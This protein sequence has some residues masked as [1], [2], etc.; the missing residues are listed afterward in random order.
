MSV[1]LSHQAAI[2]ICV[3]LLSEVIFLSSL[4]VSL[5]RVENEAQRTKHARAVQQATV[6]LLRLPI[7]AGSTLG[8]FAL[9]KSS[10]LDNQFNAIMSKLP[11]RLKVL[12][13]LVADNKKQ[14]DAVKPLER[15]FA[16]V[17]ANLQ[18]IRES[19]DG[20]ASGVPYTRFLTLRKE[21][22]A[23]FKL[24]SSQ[25]RKIL[26]I[27]AESV[28][29]ETDVEK[30]SRKQLTTSIIGGIALTVILAVMLAFQF[31][32][33]TQKRLLLLMDNTRRLSEN[34]P[35]QK[36]LNGNDELAQLDHVFHQM[37][38]SLAE[39]TRK[40]RAIVEKAADVICSITW[41]DRFTAVNP[42]SLELWGWSPDELVGRSYK[43]ILPEQDAVLMSRE[44]ESARLDSDSRRFE[45][46]LTKKD[47]TVAYMNWSVYSSSEQ[48]SYFCVVHDITDRKEIERLKQDFVAMVSHDLMT[49]LTS[50]RLFLDML[51]EGVYGTISTGGEARINLVDDNV[52][53]LLL[54]VTNL[55]DLE[56]LE[57]GGVTLYPQ[58][59]S[60]QHLVNR[61]VESV[62]GLAH[63]LGVTVESQATD[64]ISLVADGDRIVQVLVN[65]LSNAVKFSK[66]GDMVTVVGSEEDGFLLVEVIDH[67]P[68]I[69]S[70]HQKTIFER[71]KQSP[72]AS[73]EEK[74]LGFGFGLYMAKSMVNLHG[75][76]IGVE[77][78]EGKGS[79][80]WFTLPLNLESVDDSVST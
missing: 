17:T 48:E 38:E 44:L 21:L 39:A 27:E 41:T 24:M 33:S 64:E 76:E 13:M 18:E 66:S 73:T 19:I 52:N 40:E 77:S 22:D 63:E 29:L 57:V 37:A 8:T 49:P 75:G 67:G 70:E 53:R 59:V 54:L 30:D 58:P 68:G 62:V 7:D 4:L 3:P 15:S 25:A 78:E 20:D 61:S 36:R 50:V 79:T 23:E 31:F 65:L 71:F 51:R 55:L 60:F 42:A 47:G 35:L 11:E 10:E 26:D 45:T 2:L 1:K 43:E 28:N 69:P 56:K 72:D 34:R 16:R 14:S 9:T 74:K 5:D 6:D 80:F 32:Q 12:S 46:A